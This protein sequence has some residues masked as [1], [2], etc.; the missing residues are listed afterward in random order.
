MRIFQVALDT[1]LDKV[2]DYLAPDMLDVAVGMRVQVPFGRGNRSRVGVVVGISTHSDFALEKLKPIQAVLDDCPLFGDAMLDLLRWAA[3]YYHYPLGQVIATALPTLLN[4][5]RA[6]NLPGVTVWRATATD[7][8]LENLK[9]APAQQRV[10]EFLRAHPPSMAESDLRIHLPGAHRVLKELQKKALIESFTEIPPCP[11]PNT[12]QIAPPDLNAD[13]EAA[14]AQVEYGRFQV[15]LLHGITGSGK[16]EVYLRL[17]ARVL[18]QGR[19]ALVLVPEI[20][21]TPQMLARF[22]ARFRAPMAVLHS[23]LSDSERLLAW[24]RARNGEATIVIGT[25]SAVWT[26]LARPGLIVVDEEH[27]LSYKQAS[28]FHYSGRD[29]AI[30]RAQLNQVPIVLGSATPALESLYNARQERYRYLT[31]KQRAGEAKPPRIRIIDMRNQYARANLSNLLRQEIRACLDAGQQVLLFI[32]RR[33]YAPTLMCQSCGWVADCRHC[34]AHL[35]LH[36]RDGRLHCHHC[37]ATQAP[38]LVCPACAGTELN[39]LGHGSERIEEKLSEYFPQARIMRIDSDST[40]RKHAIHEMLEQIHAGAADILVG[41]HML[42]KGH[43]FP[44]VTLAGVITLDSGLFSSDFRAPERT[45]QL[46]IQVA[47][48]AGRAQAAGQVL[49]QTWHPQHPL[50]LQILNEGY[51]ACAET[52]LEERRLAALPPFSYLALLRAEARQEKTL[53]QFLHAA[54]QALHDLHLPEL[55]VWG[56]VAAPLERKADHFRGQLLLQ[57]PRRDILHHALDHWLP[58]LPQLAP[59]LRWSLDIDPLDLG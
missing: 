15:Y 53:N 41:T 9:R 20:N 6:A 12:A 24:L 50:L 35:S 30:R 54:A 38:P 49:L 18:E 32:G 5:G 59:S 1:P 10:L 2:F 27:D 46:L 16:T 42:T 14:V 22:E 7:C 52:L 37:G 17:I 3:H 26:P 47:G 51:L 40:R 8:A 4:Q 31:L 44:N 58:G 28:G 55:Q 39:L 33:G 23:Q 13:Q 11:V 57:S 19:Q 43:D 45:M 25:R 21:L 56:P 34:S 36:R 48:R 29:I